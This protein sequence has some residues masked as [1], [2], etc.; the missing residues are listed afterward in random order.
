M[1]SSHVTRRSQNTTVTATGIYGI[2]SSWLHAMQQTNATQMHHIRSKC[3][4]IKQFHK[5]ASGLTL[6]LLDNF[7]SISRMSI[8]LVMSNSNL[9]KNTTNSTYI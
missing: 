8:I 2:Y 5:L 9:I 6:E 3:C 7:V 1:H 4:T